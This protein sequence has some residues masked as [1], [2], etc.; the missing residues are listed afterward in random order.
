MSTYK[1]QNANITLHKEKSNLIHHDSLFKAVWDWVILAFVIYT[2]IE[3]PFMVAFVLPS[4]DSGQFGALF[5]LSPIAIGNLVVD[6]FFII[7]IPINF[8]SASV[9]KDTDEV[10]TNLKEIAILYLKTWF[11]V[12]F[13]AAIPFE[14]VIDPEH[15]RV[16]IKR[17]SML[18]YRGGE[19]VL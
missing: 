8:L 15:E 13:I 19:G 4:Q 10:I 2:A 5:A 12:D 3:I 9:N 14:Y 17:F 18:L 11:V 16:G 6:L 7:D 1:P